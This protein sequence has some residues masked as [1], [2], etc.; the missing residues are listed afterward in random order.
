VNLMSWTPDLKKSGESSDARRLTDRN[1][2]LQCL[3]DSSFEK[4]KPQAQPEP[5]QVQEPEEERRGPAAYIPPPEEEEGPSG[6]ETD[7]FGVK[8]TE[9]MARPSESD[10]GIPNVVRQMIQYLANEGLYS[11]DIFKFQRPKAQLEPLINQINTGEQIKWLDYDPMFIA[12]LLKQYLTDLPE[13]V[14][15]FA[16]YKAFV[17]AGSMPPEQRSKAI[18]KTFNE[19]PPL[20]KIFCEILFALLARVA[21]NKSYTMMTASSLGG[22]FGQLV[23]SPENPKE[24]LAWIPKIN[25]VGKELVDLIGLPLV[26]QQKKEG[27]IVE[28]K[29]QPKAQ[30]LKPEEV[31]QKYVEDL[32]NLVPAKILANPNAERHLAGIKTPS[33]RPLNLKQRQLL[34]EMLIM[35]EEEILNFKT[36][37]LNVQEKLNGLNSLKGVMGIARIVYNIKAIVV[38]G[39]ELP[40]VG[41]PDLP[42]DAPSDEYRNKVVVSKK[43]VEGSITT[44]LERLDQI[45]GGLNKGNDVDQIDNMKKIMDIIHLTALAILTL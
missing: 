15:T 34:Q 2:L 26:E 5:A 33:L 14:L 20:N 28:V 17:D 25:V 6:E 3:A 32:D 27:L 16:K 40:N 35:T 39:R 10:N 44:I 43:I 18:L 1:L 38:D 12:D 31:V 11:K 45:M 41:G 7:V 8:L 9:V 24:K 22:I 4:K 42:E 36:K 23:L 19:L 13:P 30:A 21:E 29:P 37:L